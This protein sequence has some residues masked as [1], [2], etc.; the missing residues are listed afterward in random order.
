M[1][2]FTRKFFNFQLGCYTWFLNAHNDNVQNVY[3]SWH[4]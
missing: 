4:A 3:F 1:A 2:E